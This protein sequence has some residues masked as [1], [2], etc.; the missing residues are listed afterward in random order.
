MHRPRRLRI[1]RQRELLLPVERVPRIADRV[2]AIPRAWPVPRDVR[3]VRRNLVRDHPILHVLLVGQPQMLLRRHVAQHARAMPADQRSANRARDVVVAGGNVR[4]QRAKGIKRRPETVLHFLVHLLLDLVQRHMPRSF[5]HHLHVALPRLRRQLAQRLQL[6]ELRIV[7]SIGDRPW[8]EPVAQREAHVVLRHRLHDAIEVL[9]QEI[10]PV[11]VRHPLRQDRAA[12]AH[13]PRDAL[14]HHRHILDQHARMNR[15][16]VHTLR[17][18]LLDHLKINVNIEVLEPLHARQRLINRDRPNR[19]RRVPQDGVANLRNIAARRQIHHRVRPMLDRH[20]QLA[21]F[22]VDVRRDRRVADVRV[23][24]APRRDPNPHRLQFRMVHVG[25]NDQ[26][27]HSHF[28]ADHF[29]RQILALRHVGHF[30]REQ[31][32]AR[33]VHLR[34]VGVTGARGLSL[35]AHDPVGARFQNL[36]RWIGSSHRSPLS[37]GIGVAVR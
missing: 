24:L 33:K 11:V 23:H 12:A 27:P 22:F 7:R 28:V 1:E 6:T 13:N 37:V 4:D 5:D 19:H 32:F 15:E 25:R 9:V 17:G 30:F 2:V 29:H 21:Q 16:I 8:P 36:K 34:Q 26:P 14:R 3:R 35:A 10:L 18:L 20:M 31:A